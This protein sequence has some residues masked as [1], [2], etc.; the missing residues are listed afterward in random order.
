MLTAEALGEN[1]E[2]VKEKTGE[3]REYK[4]TAVIGQKDSEGADC[5]YPPAPSVSYSFPHNR[6]VHWSDFCLWR[7]GDNCWTQRGYRVFLDVEA[8][9]S[10]AFDAGL[11]SVIDE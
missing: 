5:A 6:S 4:S 10:G 3:F 11:F 7:F 8:L 2:S 1:V 9:A